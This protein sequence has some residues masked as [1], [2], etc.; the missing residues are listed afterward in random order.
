MHYKLENMTAIIKK[1]ESKKAEQLMGIRSNS[2]N[3]SIIS[4]NSSFT[5][6]KMGLVMICLCLVLTLSMTSNFIF[7]RELLI[8]SVIISLVTAIK[9][10]EIKSI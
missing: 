2:N 3:Q 1:V 5:F 10:F 4:R 7:F 8:S 6:L 9:F